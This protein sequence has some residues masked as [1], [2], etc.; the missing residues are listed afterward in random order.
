M[1]EVL[2][3][4]DLAISQ[5]E[6]AEEAEREE[7][8]KKELEGVRNL[9]NVMEGVIAAMSKAKENMDVSYPLSTSGVVLM[10]LDCGIN[11]GE[12]R[13]ITGYMD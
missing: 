6:D 7:A 2:R 8:L 10:A 13:S 12:C 4:E 9:N 1:E 3:I 5:N 11:S